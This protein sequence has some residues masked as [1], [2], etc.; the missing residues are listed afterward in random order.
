[1]L[2]RLT[3]LNRERVQEEKE[4]VIR[5]LR[6]EFQ[7]PYGT[8]TAVQTEMTL[9]RED[10]PVPLKVPLPKDHTGQLQAVRT[11]LAAFKGPVA[12][13]ELAQCFLKARTAR[14][15][16]LLDDLVKLGLG[17]KEGEKYVA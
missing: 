6:P 11:A 16:T 13:D 8:A 15:T 3:A 10:K 9:V 4:G 5:W 2:A 7:N 12:P 17:R 14:V 1:I